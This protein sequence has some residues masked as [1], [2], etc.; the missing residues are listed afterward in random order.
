MA[1]RLHRS[2][3]S[4]DEVCFSYTPNDKT[5]IYNSSALTGVFLARI[6]SAVRQREYL[7]LAR[8][9]MVFLQRGQL[10]KRRMVLRATSAATL[11]RQFSY[12]VQRL[13]ATGLSAHHRGP[14]L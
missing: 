8:K 2:F 6:G 3:E 1:T 9:A 11:D 14:K 12:L 4:A 7:S 5:L 10:R 13:R